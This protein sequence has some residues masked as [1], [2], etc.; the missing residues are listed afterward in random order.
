MLLGCFQLTKTLFKKPY[1]V[2]QNMFSA[3]LNTHTVSFIFCSVL[4]VSKVELCF[5]RS[6]CVCVC[7]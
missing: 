7:V 1:N 6:V 3:S 2:K 5:K 4:F